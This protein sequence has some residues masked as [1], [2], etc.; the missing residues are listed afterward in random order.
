MK[1]PRKIKRYTRIY[2]TRKQVRRASVMKIVILVVV[3]AA[4]VFVGYSVAGPVMD[5]FSGNIKPTLPSDSSSE[6]SSDSSLPSSESSEPVVQ[7][8]MVAVTVPSETLRDT[9]AFES[10]LSQAKQQ[11]ANAVVVELKNQDGILQYRSAVPE[12]AT[13]GAVASD[14]VELA[15]LLEKAESQQ[16]TVIAKLSAF[17]DKTAPNASR[18]NGYLYEGSTS[19]WWD[20]TPE[21]G[22]KPW[23]NPYKTAACDYLIAIQN[24]LAEAGVT[25]ILWDKVE[26][27][28]V[29]RLSSADF[30][31]EADGIS[32]QQALENFVQRSNSEGAQKGVTVWVSYPAS[33]AFG[34]NASWFGNSNP[35]QWSS[36]LHVAPVLDFSSFGATAEIGGTQINMSDRAAATTAIVAQ[37]QTMIGA[38]KEMIPVIADAADLSVVTQALETMG[39]SQ[40]IS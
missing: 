30:G 29:S 39:I 37:L 10:F 13:Y 27:P 8:S 4:L 24:E 3:L 23:L 1:K 38:D 16:M 35:A 5:F 17:K 21:N 9:A 22:G 33:A 11:G 40:R 12:A 36:V 19:A 31:P 6:S 18:N 25:H 14:A 34:F 26:F 20:N 32:Q 7:D 15:P 28:E 2:R